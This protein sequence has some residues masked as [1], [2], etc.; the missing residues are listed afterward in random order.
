MGK[1]KGWLSFSSPLARA[2]SIGSLCFAKKRLKN[3]RSVVLNVNL[4]IV[5]LTLLFFLIYISLCFALH[6]VTRA[7]SRGSLR[8]TPLLL[9]R[10]LL[11]RFLLARFASPFASSLARSRVVRF[12]RQL[13]FCFVPCSCVFSW[14]ALLRPSRRHLRVLA[15]LASQD[16]SPFASSLAR[17]FSLGSLCFALRVVTCAFS[18]GPLRKTL[19]MQSLLTG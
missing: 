12:A 19:E 10:P 2:F 17:A 4:K 6:G 1:R 8:K 5:K 15:W 3:L 18:R 13:S 9:L 16:S 7:F 11:V 14:L